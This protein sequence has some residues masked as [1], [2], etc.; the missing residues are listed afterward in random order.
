MHRRPLPTFR[1]VLATLTVGMCL[2]AVVPQ[3][4]LGVLQQNAEVLLRLDTTIGPELYQSWIY[5][6]LTGQRG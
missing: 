6:F 5:K 2:Q 4:C 3:G 1:L